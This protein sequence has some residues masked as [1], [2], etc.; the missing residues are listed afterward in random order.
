MTRRRWGRL[1]E[2]ALF[3]LIDHGEAN[4]RLIAGYC[5]DNEPANYQL[6]NVAR[7]ARSIAYRVRREGNQW[8][9]RLKVGI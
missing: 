3:A 9:W 1:Q 8:I 6:F 4:T 7:A 2:Q 5:W